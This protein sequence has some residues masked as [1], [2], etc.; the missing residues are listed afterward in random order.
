ME[1]KGRDAEMEGGE[2]EEG[3]LGDLVDEVVVDVLLQAESEGKA[4]RARRGQGPR[5]TIHDK[6][7]PAP[8]SESLVL[9]RSV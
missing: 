5:H 4:K 3:Y 6:C 8:R 1:R 9:L 2:M 7:R